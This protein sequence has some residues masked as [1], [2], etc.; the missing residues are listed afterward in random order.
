MLSYKNLDKMYSGEY[1][2][3]DGTMPTKS[4]EVIRIA[5]KYKLKKF[6]TLNF[7]QVEL[8]RIIVGSFPIRNHSFHNKCRHFFLPKKSELPNGCRIIKKYS[9]II[10][11]SCFN[12]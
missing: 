7:S 8:Y 1:A 11:A 2:G 12:S 10:Y 3:F 5:R 4:Y 9:E 6:C